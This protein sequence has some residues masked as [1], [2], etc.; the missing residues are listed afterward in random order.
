MMWPV[1]TGYRPDKIVFGTTAYEAFLNHPDVVDRL[2]YTM[3]P[4]PYANQVNQVAASLLDLSEVLVPRG[5]QNTAAE[6]QTDAISYIGNATNVLLVY[7]APAPSIRPPSGGLHVLVRR[8]GPGVTNAF[9]G[10]LMR[11]R[12]EL[13]HCDVFEIQRVPMISQSL[14]LIWAR[15]SSPSCRSQL[16]PQSRSV[17]GRHTDEAFSDP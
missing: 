2:K 3:G 16:R 15:C 7:A 8:F 12:E 11:G 1:K 6:G 9:G 13:A 10:V 17:A 5:V 4:A 14:R